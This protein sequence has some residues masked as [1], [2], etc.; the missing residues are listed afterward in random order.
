M[1]RTQEKET[2]GSEGDGICSPKDRMKKVGFTISYIILLSVYFLGY[3][4]DPFT[5]NFAGSFLVPQDMVTSKHQFP[6]PSSLSRL[7]RDTLQHLLRS[8]LKLDCGEQGTIMAEDFQADASPFA[9]YLPSS[10]NNSKDE[11]QLLKPILRDW[12][13]LCS[14]DLISFPLYLQRQEIGRVRI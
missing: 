6:Q 8:C 10:S 2:Q 12:N 7:K 4:S 5:R 13:E 11:E 14:G 9:C 1:K 3:A